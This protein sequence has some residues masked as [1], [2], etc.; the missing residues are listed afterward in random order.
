MD[1]TNALNEPLFGRNMKIEIKKLNQPSDT[2]MKIMLKWQNDPQIRHLYR[3]FKGPEEYQKFVNFE[4]LKCDLSCDPSTQRYGLYV[5][6]S[7]V[8]EFSF[9]FNHHALRKFDSKTAWIGIVIGEKEFR[10]RGLGKIAIQYLENE[11]IAQGG[12]RI[13]LGVFEFNPPAIH[14]YES[15][16]YSRF[17]VI[18][19]FTWWNEKFWS[20]YRYEKNL[21]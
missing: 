3:W 11:V 18:P 1:G 13:E 16:G 8:G 6:E 21:K 20:D 5:D 4:Q 9:A 12:N 17:D 15:L 14:L 7:L 10:G 2:D 19:D